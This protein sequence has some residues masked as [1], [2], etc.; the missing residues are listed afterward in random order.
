MRP[1]A[2][3]IIISF[4]TLLGCGHST[5]ES[6]VQPIRMDKEMPDFKSETK[7]NLQLLKLPDSDSW[8]LKLDGFSNSLD[9]SFT[10]SG[11]TVVSLIHAD[12][13]VPQITTEDILEYNSSIVSVDGD[14][15]LP[16]KPGKSILVYRHP[17]GIDT[18]FVRIN[19]NLHPTISQE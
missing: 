3:L 17:K 13:A 5:E 7:F 8:F 15:L 11:D 6:K 19:K 16:V 2:I 14:I 9:T 12:L 10:T 4:L 18:T 1:I